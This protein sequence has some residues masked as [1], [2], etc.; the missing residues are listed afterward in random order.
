MSD[1][2]VYYLSLSISGLALAIIALAIS[3]VV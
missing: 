2:S 1:E 3:L